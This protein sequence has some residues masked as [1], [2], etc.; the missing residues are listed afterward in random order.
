VRSPM[1]SDNRKKA[2]TIDQ[3]NVESLMQIWIE[4]EKNVNIIHYE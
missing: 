3:S 2:K 4:I 1:R